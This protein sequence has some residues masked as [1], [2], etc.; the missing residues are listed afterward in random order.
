MLI[1]GTPAERRVRSWPPAG[2]MRTRAARASP[3]AYCLS[4]VVTAERMVSIWDRQ[5]S[6]IIGQPGTTVEGGNAEETGAH[7]RQ[8]RTCSS[9]QIW[10]T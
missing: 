1:R 5:R 9:L 2:L 6:S 3:R 8:R 7:G 10:H 4:H